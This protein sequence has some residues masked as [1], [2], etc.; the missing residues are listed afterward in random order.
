MARPK[1]VPRTEGQQR[2]I[3]A[4]EQAKQHADEADERMWKAARAARALGVPATFIAK[5]TGK[6]R[7]LL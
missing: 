5:K 7:Y 3:A 4:L 1:W 2:A 6:T